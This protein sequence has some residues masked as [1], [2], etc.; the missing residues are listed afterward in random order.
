[1]IIMIVK[2]IWIIRFFISHVSFCFVLLLFF[3]PSFS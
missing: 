1:M 2:K 3:V